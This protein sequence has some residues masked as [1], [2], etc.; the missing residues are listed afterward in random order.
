M[1][2]SFNVT[3]DVRCWS[4]GSSPNCGFAL[5]S[6]AGTIYLRSREYGP[7]PPSLEIAYLNGSQDVC[8]SAYDEALHRPATVNVTLTVNDVPNANGKIN[9]S[10]GVWDRGAWWPPTTGTWNLGATSAD[11]SECVSASTLASFTLGSPTSMVSLDGNLTDASAGSVVSSFSLC[12]SSLFSFNGMT[13]NFFVNGTY[14]SG[15]PY[16]SSGSSTTLANGT[17][18]FEWNAP[19]NGTFSVH[20]TFGGDAFYL[21]CDAYELVTVNRLPLSTLFTVSPAEFKPGDCIT[22]N[23]TVIDPLTSQL[24]TNHNVTVQFFE[25]ISNGTKCAVG[26]PV[27]STLGVSTLSLNYP[28]D[29]NAYAYNATI[30]GCTDGLET[31]SNVVSNPVQLTVGSSAT[32]DSIVSTAST[33]RTIDYWFEDPV[34]HR[35]LYL[36]GRQIT[37]KINGTVH[38]GQCLT[39]DGYTGVAEFSG[40]FQ[41]VNNSTT[42]Y[43]ITASFAGDNPVSAS[44]N[45]TALDGSCYATCT[46]VK[47][48]YDATTCGYETSSNCIVIT[49]TPQSTQAILSKGIGRNEGLQLWGPDSFCLWPPFFKL[50]AKVIVDSL[51]SNVQNWVGL[52]ACGVD[53]YSGLLKPLQNAFQLTPIDIDVVTGA[54]TAVITGISTLYWLNMIAASVA[55]FTLEG[56]LADL[57]CYT[58][59]LMAPIWVAYSIPDATLSKAILYGICFTLVGLT[60]GAFWND[61]QARLFPSILRL[62]LPGADPVTTSV[63]YVLNNCFLTTAI[64]AANLLMA[65]IVMINP[66]MWPFATITFAMALVALDLVNSR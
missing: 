53:S 7:C 49:V 2:L 45:S 6:D 48:N 65:S 31:V 27:N 57:A 20:A 44:A 12:L 19:D 3:D 60:M 33:K 62:Q 40:D 37:V 5:F 22:L 11:M 9:E 58:V 38:D 46:T 17:V 21:P 59:A 61:P 34:F 50:H 66:L 39:T 35:N 26:P 18:R 51:G 14:G 8:V 28:N 54:I 13:V 23:A 24:F 25:S 56:Y 29:S 1:W 64:T 41:A 16:N 42:T 10:T 30:L 52:F 36:T 55:E 43:T 15:T 4:N 47:Y 63:K 32:L